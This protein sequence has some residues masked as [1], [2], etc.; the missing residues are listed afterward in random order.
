MHVCTQCIVPLS[1]SLEQQNVRDQRQS[2]VNGYR[3]AIVA[4]KY[5][6]SQK[7]PFGVGY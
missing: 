1:G 5:S 2:L 3:Q 4:R 6:S 7:S